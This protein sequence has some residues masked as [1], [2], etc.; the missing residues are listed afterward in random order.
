MN[1]RLRNTL[2]TITAYLAIIGALFLFFPSVAESVFGISLPD[3]AL[4]M[5][6]GQVVLTLAF[7]AYL[8]ASKGESHTGFIVLF[9]GHILVFLY[10]IMI[11]VATFAQNG[12]PLVISIIFTVLLFVFG[13]K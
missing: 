3:A 7:M 6:Y 2:Y 12:P 5:L 9:G 4:T 8:A 10:Q 1:T 13:R 11:G